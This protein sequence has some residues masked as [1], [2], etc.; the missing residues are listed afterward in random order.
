MLVRSGTTTMY[1]FTAYVEG[2]SGG[3]VH[4]QKQQQLSDKVRGS[5]KVLCSMHIISS[6]HDHFTTV[7]GGHAGEDA[8]N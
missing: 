7:V 8:Q 5:A 1:H 3:H 6:Q 4:R 2:L